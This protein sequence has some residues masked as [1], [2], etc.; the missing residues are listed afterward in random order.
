[1]ESI[2]LITAGIQLAR[3]ICSRAFN[4]LIWFEIVFLTLVLKGLQL[5]EELNFEGNMD[6][7]Y[8]GLYQGDCS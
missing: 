1:M 5:T 4:L 8:K 6:E 7:K 3:S 2:V